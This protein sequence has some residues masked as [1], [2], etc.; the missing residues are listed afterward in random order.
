MLRMKRQSNLASVI[1]LGLLAAA[2]L[3]AL[4]AHALVPPPPILWTK[5]LSDTGNPS[6]SSAPGGGLFLGTSTD[7]TGAVV[8]L[9]SNGN[10]V[11]RQPLAA[12]RPADDVAADA[13]GNVFVASH[14]IGNP[15]NT[16]LQKYSPT[17]SLL[18]TQQVVTPRLDMATGVDVDPAGNAYIAN[19]PWTTNYANAPAGTFNS[20]HRYATDS[21]LAWSRN[22]DTGDGTSPGG[23]GPQSGGVAVDHSGHVF[24]AFNN[25]HSTQ[26]NNTFVVDSYAYLSK[27]SLDGQVLWVKEHNTNFG[28]ITGIAVDPH[29]NVYVAASNSFRKYDSEG[30]QLWSVTNNNL[31]LMAVTIGPGGEIFAAGAAG[32]DTYIAQYN[33]NG[34]V[35]WSDIHLSGPDQVSRYQS[36]TIAG[37]KLV[38]AGWIAT[39][40]TLSGN[41]VRAYQLVP[42]PTAA[43]L[44][45]VGVTLNVLSSRRRLS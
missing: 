6:L 33:S 41:L 20:L 4:Q 18:W 13:A 17:G 26:V 9:D 14:Q 23:S 21:T 7:T 45:L 5:A 12:S 38:V 37:D 25:Y 30:N 28:D 24:S 36:L 35:V 16:F 39:Q 43:A 22:L 34:S 44:L 42:E 29:D 19:A 2:A 40:Q 10:E 3:A 8:R 15:F 11:W 32:F 1:A 31:A 27:T